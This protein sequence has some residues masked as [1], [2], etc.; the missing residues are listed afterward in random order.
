MQEIASLIGQ[1]VGNVR[2]HYYRA[3]EKMRRELFTAPLQG[4]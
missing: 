3:L 4:K 2:N 1:S